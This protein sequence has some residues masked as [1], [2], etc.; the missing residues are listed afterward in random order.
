MRGHNYNNN[1]YNSQEYNLL[2][3]GGTFKG[4]IGECMFKLANPK[5][6][7]TAFYPKKRFIGY[8][9]N[10]LTKEQIK[11]L[12]SHWGSIDAIDV[13]RIQNKN[14]FVLYEIKTR[15]RYKKDLHYKPKMTHATHIIYEYAKNLGFNISLVTI[16]LEHNWNYIIQL[17]EYNQKNYCIDKPKKYDN[18]KL[19]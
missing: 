11:F 14:I 12:N 10:S 17:S 16:W 13:K 8:F 15:N 5:I 9:S 2:H 7:L 3:F 1:V 6:T 4:I 18:K 19:F